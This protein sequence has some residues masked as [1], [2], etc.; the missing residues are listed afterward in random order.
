MNSLF[1]KQ[2]DILATSRGNFD[3]ENSGNCWG[4]KN[5]LLNLNGG[6]FP[7]DIKLLCHPK[8]IKPLVGDLY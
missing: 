6:V 8:N 7:I 1:G 3:T 5:I 4:K 2:L